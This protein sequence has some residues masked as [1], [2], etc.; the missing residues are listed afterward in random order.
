[1]V[2][3]SSDIQWLLQT[4]EVIIL[5]LVDIRYLKCQLCYFQWIDRFFARSYH[6]HYVVLEGWNAAKSLIRYKD[7]AIRGNQCSMTLHDFDRARPML[8][9]SK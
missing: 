9:A 7:P 1:M 4:G 3:S 8:D 6:G 2:L 5:A